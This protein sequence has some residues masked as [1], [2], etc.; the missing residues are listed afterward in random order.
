MPQWVLAGLLAHVSRGT[1][2]RV[3][4][5]GCAGDGHGSALSGLPRVGRRLP[6]RFRVSRET[7]SATPVRCLTW[8]VVAWGP[9]TAARVVHGADACRTGEAVRS[10]AGSP[11]GRAA[12]V[13]ADVRAARAVRRATGVP[14]ICA[15]WPRE[16]GAPAG[17]MGDAYATHRHGALS[18]VPDPASGSSERAPRHLEAGVHASQRGQSASSLPDGGVAGHPHLCRLT[19]PGGAAQRL[20]TGHAEVR[21]W[22]LLTSRVSRPVQGLLPAA[23]PEAMPLGTWWRALPVVSRGTCASPR[24]L[25]APGLMRWWPCLVA[26]GTWAMRC[27]LVVEG[28]TR[29]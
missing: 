26:R 3:A 5:L 8:S 4:G 16:R 15:T 18:G 1:C 11:L 27:G 6:R 14:G 25:S 29:R 2:A 13:W 17:G 10:D 21:G 20:C 28:S 9:G 7:G 12:L 24:G 22:R 23:A 19:G